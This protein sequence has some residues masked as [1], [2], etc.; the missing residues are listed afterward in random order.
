MHSAKASILLYN[1]NLKDA[2]YWNNFLFS[3]ANRTSPAVFF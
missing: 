3:M 1:N 2:F